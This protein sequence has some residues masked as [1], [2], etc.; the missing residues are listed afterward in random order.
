MAKTVLEF[1]VPDCDIGDV[2]MCRNR[3]IDVIRDPEFE[4]FIRG[5]ELNRVVAGGAPTPR[6]GEGS[7]SCHAESGGGW[8]CEGRVSFSF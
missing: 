3:M 1:R 6:G 8:G 7:I 5:L 2:D 4:S